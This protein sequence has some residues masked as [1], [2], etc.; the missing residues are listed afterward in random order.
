MK[1]AIFRNR[2]I[3]DTPEKSS[4]PLFRAP[5]E[6]DPTLTTPEKSKP[7]PIKTN[8]GFIETKEKEEKVHLAPYSP[9]LFK[10]KNLPVKFKPNGK[11]YK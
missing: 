4:L 9:I 3:P 2:E 8:L 7:N 5:G 1:Y 10:A 6:E 11:P